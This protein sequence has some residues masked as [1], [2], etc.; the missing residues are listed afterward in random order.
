MIGT[1]ISFIQLS[2]QMASFGSTPLVILLIFL[3]FNL[4]TTAISAVLPPT[5]PTAQTPKSIRESD[6]IY[7]ATSLAW[8]TTSSANS[9]TFE[10]IRSIRQTNQ[11]VKPPKAHSQQKPNSPSS[12]NHEATLKDFQGSKTRTVYYYTSN[13]RNITPSITSAESLRQ[14]NIQ[15]D[16]DNGSEDQNEQ[17]PSKDGAN[18]KSKSK[19]NKKKQQNISM[20]I[21]AIVGSSLGLI[22]GILCI[23]YFCYHRAKKS[24]QVSNEVS[25]EAYI[26]WDPEIGPE[27]ITPAAEMLKQVKEDKRLSIPWGHPPQILSTLN[28]K[29]EPK[30][31]SYLRLCTSPTVH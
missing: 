30:W 6:E 20:L 4:Y 19:S 2:P 17:T 13:E 21:V 28:V 31:K 29:P 16:N 11:P 23:S 25:K 15:S 26:G 12:E 22:L 10:F 1:A 27:Q 3:L 24:T 8:S 14:K 9:R 18:S 7:G 5:N